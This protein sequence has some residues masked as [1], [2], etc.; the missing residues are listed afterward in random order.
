MGL[1]Y[2]HMQ[3]LLKDLPENQFQE[4]IDFIEF[5]KNKNEK[6]EKLQEKRK[7]LR[8][9][10]SNTSVTDEDI[11]EAKNIWKLP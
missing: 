11:E 8:G 6:I 10:I 9:L 7:S 3:K 2:N 1:N 4:V 5:L